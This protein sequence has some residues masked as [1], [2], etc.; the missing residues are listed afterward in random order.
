MPILGPEARAFR[1][2]TVWA[3]QYVREFRSLT[4][5][6]VRAQQQ[7]GRRSASLTTS[8]VPQDNAEESGRI[9]R[10]YSARGVRTLQNSSGGFSGL[11]EERWT[12]KTR[13]EISAICPWL[14]MSISVRYIARAGQRS[15]IRLRLFVSQ[16]AEDQSV[17]TARKPHVSPRWTKLG[18]E[19]V[20]GCKPRRLCAG[21]AEN[22]AT[23]RRKR[24]RFQ[25]TVEAAI[26]GV[27]SAIVRQAERPFCN[28]APG[29]TPAC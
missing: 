15:F 18:R 24:A 13:K 8:A 26:L 29:L 19:D 7:F 25:L 14:S 21:R 11:V 6:P 16:Y 1:L 10:E 20:S 22:L 4:Q 23:T 17:C 2:R 27:E 9:H 12:F 3:G 5:K 28:A